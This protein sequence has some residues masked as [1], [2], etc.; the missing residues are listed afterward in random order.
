VKQCFIVLMLSVALF[1]PHIVSAQDDIPRVRFSYSPPSLFDDRDFAYN[2]LFGS[3]EVAVV[4]DYTTMYYAVPAG[5][6]T[7]EFTASDE[8]SSFSTEISLEAGNRYTVISVGADQPVIVVNETVAEAEL[9]EVENTLTIVTPSATA[10]TFKVLDNL[11]P[12]PRERVLFEYSG[13]LQSGI[14]ENGVVIQRLDPQTQAVI[15][16]VN[17]PYFPNTDVL[18]NGERLNDTATPLVI[19]YSTS[20]STADWLAGI[21]QMT[22]PPFTFNEFINSAVV[23]GFDAALAECADYMWFPWTD[24]AFAQQSSDNQSFISGAGAAEI[25]NDSVHEGASTTPW[26]MSPTNTRGG[27]ALFFGAPLAELDSTT[28]TAGSLSGNILMTIS[29]TGNGVQN[30]IHITD[31]VPSGETAQTPVEDLTLYPS[32]TTLNLVLPFGPGS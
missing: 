32:R 23:G 9:A 8:A 17:I 28:P 7:I 12:T 5:G 21:N 2:F 19:N 3:S 22:N 11:S 1:A 26:L 10:T 27:T 29:T 16:S 6:Q 4:P 25:L 31:A 20:L 18:I 14:G 30:V 15:S 24:G 13:Y